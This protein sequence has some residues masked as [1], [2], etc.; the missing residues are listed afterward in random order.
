MT[1]IER[2]ASRFACA[3]ARSPPFA[4]LIGPSML[5]RKSEIVASAIRARD[6][7]STRT[8]WRIAA[9]PNT[10]PARAN[11]ANP[12]ASLGLNLARSDRPAAT[13]GET[14]VFDRARARPVRVGRLHERQPISGPTEREIPDESGERRPMPQGLEY[15]RTV[16]PRANNHSSSASRSAALAAARIVQTGRLKRGEI[17]GRTACALTSV[18]P[19]RAPASRRRLAA[20]RRR[21][22]PHARGVGASPG[23]DGDAAP[24]AAVGA[25]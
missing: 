18:A 21:R 25:C 16:A 24:D 12:A 11:A 9:S 7:P 8:S 20:R 1:C 22:A 19:A 17:L 3:N 13:L 15:L 5:T 6:V 4:S 23:G 14:Q 2:I 10:S